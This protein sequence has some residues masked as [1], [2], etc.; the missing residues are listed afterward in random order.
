MALWVVTLHNDMVGYKCFG[1]SCYLSLQG[2]T[3][4]RQQLE[5]SLPCK[6]QV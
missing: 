2:E 5:S 1:G 6:P 3:S 4:R